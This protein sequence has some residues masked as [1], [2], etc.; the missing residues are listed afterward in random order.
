MDAKLVKEEFINVIPLLSTQLINIWSRLSHTEQ[1]ILISLFNR[2]IKRIK[3]NGV[4]W[5]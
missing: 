2:D 4:C 3:N 1:E 5:C